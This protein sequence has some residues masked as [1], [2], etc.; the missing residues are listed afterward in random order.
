MAQGLKIEVL[1]VRLLEESVKGQLERDRERVAKISTA[2]A[3]LIRDRYKAAILPREKTGEL[4]KSM[5]VTAARKRSDKPTATVRVKDMASVWLEY[6]TVHQEAQPTMA[7]IAAEVRKKHLA[8]LKG[9]V[10]KE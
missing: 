6:G 8:E 5:R 1:G 3:R 9:E 2:N 4:R 10:G 7:P